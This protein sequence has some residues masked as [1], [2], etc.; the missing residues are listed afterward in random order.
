MALTISDET[1]PTP[2][3]LA[4]IRKGRSEIPAMGAIMKGTASFSDPIISIFVL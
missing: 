1:S 3:L 2:N 4:I